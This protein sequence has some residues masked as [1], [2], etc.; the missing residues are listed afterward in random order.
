MSNV[1]HTTRPFRRDDSSLQ[2]L[3]EAGWA[4][5]GMTQWVAAWVL[6][7][8]LSASWV[9]PRAA[10]SV[11]IEHVRVG[12]AGKFKVGATTPIEVDL[13]GGKRPVRGQLSVSTTD[14]DG[15]AN[16]TESP[17][18]P[19]EI[20]PEQQ[21]T[22]ALMVQLGKVPCQ[23][24]VDLQLDSGRLIRQPFRDQ[25][26]TQGVL[27]HQQLVVAVGSD[28][29]CAQALRQMPQGTDIV[30]A[31][32]R[33]ATE[34][35]REW[36]A[37]D[38]VD[39][40]VLTMGHSA[41][42]SGQ[43]ILNMEPQ[44]AAALAQWVALGGRLLISAGAHGADI[45]E[46]GGALASL[47]PG[48]YEGTRALAEGS[49]VEKFS[50]AVAP[51]VAAGSVPSQP[52]PLVT[53]LGNISGRV[54][55]AAD[56]R[57]DHQPL[58]IRAPHGLG[59]VVFVG[60][61][62]DAPLVAQWRDRPRFVVQLLGMLLGRGESDSRERPLQRVSHAGYQDLAGQLRGALD[63]FRGVR[64][65]PFSLIVAGAVV[66][67][68]LSSF[69]DYLLL[70]HVFRRM[71]GTWLT[72]PLW[73]LGF[74]TL[75]YGAALS[76]KGDQ[77][78][79]RQIDMVDLDL[80]HEW[81]RGTTWAHVFSP[82]TSELDLSIRPLLSF[83]A[84]SASDGALISWLGLV[85]R[86]FGGL[87][88]PAAMEILAHPYRLEQGRRGGNSWQQTV[89]QFPLRVWSS[90]AVQGKWWHQG[91]PASPKAKGQEAAGASWSTLR[92]DDERSASPSSRGEL[93]GQFRNPLPVPLEDIRLMYGR[94]LYRPSGTAATLAPG[95]Q[96]DVAKQMRGQ[97]LDWALTRRRPLTGSTK[98]LVDVPTPWDIKSQDVPRIVEMIQFHEAAGGRHYTELSNCGLH[99][100]DLSD[101]LGLGRAILC[102]RVTQPAVALRNA[103]KPLTDVADV[104]DETWVFY[105]V[106]F[107][108][109]PK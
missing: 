64:V 28:I 59:Q 60:F 95:E 100:L 109:A 104:R 37:Y 35:P 89:Q 96:M 51:L 41:A 24:T 73:V 11:A 8:L 27:T 21:Q 61:D 4:W 14:S 86:G 99:A 65:I 88:S 38:G 102:G 48:T 80:Q 30:L 94:W 91:L 63:Q 108:V 45:I 68:G 70:K 1:A 82:R 67:I 84:Q 97:L 2:S 74:G 72:F 25:Q 16:V 78:R 83:P 23:F 49:S 47:V 92:R 57:G 29:G 36:Q 52:L 13:S 98:S 34:L 9:V 39:L 76:W 53:I 6:F 101:H 66:C 71:Q 42:G 56:A 46:R 106:V 26:R 44:R 69:G 75:A 87:D 40:V 62:L 81:V 19:V 105:R 77:L 10:A 90:R 43:T 12:F 107:P 85:G 58:V 32:L 31:A 22:A 20:L 33:D 103:D 93:Q 3:G 50:H 17:Y 7:L 5:P 79:V 55:L 18:D 54:E 15:Y